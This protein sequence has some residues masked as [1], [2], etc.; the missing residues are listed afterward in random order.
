M[1]DE[2]QRVSPEAGATVE[3]G[4]LIQLRWWTLAAW[5]VALVTSDAGAVG[6]ALIGGAAASNLAL[7]ALRG[8]LG[9]ARLTGAVLVLDALLLTGLLHASGGPMNPFTALYFVYITMAAVLLSRV[10]IVALLLVSLAGYGALFLLAEP[11]HHAGHGMAAHL[12]G[13]WIAFGITAFLVA[14]FVTRLR[15]LVARRD[16]ALAEARDRE[17]RT[18]RVAALSGLAS[19]AAHELGTPLG[20]IALTAG[21][22]ERS[23]ADVDLPHAARG[24]LR[25]IREE[26]ARC[27]SI[28]AGLAHVAGDVP[29][30]ALAEVALGELVDGAL[31]RVDASRVSMNIASDEVA[32]LPAAAVQVALRNLLQNALDA[33]DGAVELRGAVEGGQVRLEVRD[34]GRGMS[35]EALRRAT[36][37]FYSTKAEH[38]GTGL[39]LFLVDA[40]AEQLGGRL[41]LDSSPG[42]GTTA[43]LVLPQ[44]IV[45]R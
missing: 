17:A 41:E 19:G 13:M 35:E 6:Y 2:T 22:L 34:H 42:R 8:R 9:S 12:R 45:A 23:L 10:W 30:E 38:E 21:E 39:G 36:E 14:L 4:W 25:L 43:R 44:G 33:G 37:P 20:T 32:R 7:H 31:S 26:V 24:D 5:L 18:R 29:G 27:R 15:G 1:D 3:P 16:A 40:V 28:L 11:S